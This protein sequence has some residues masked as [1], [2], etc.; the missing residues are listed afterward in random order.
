[1]QASDF[2][3]WH[4]LLEPAAARV[5]GTGG[6]RRRGREYL[7]GHFQVEVGERID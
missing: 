5:F 2:A 1:V 3:D 4:N 6:N 7:K